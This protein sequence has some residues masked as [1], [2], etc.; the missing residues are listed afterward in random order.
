MP[1]TKAMFS[2]SRIA[3]ERIANPSFSGIICPLCLTHIQTF[4]EATREHVPPKALGGKVL[5]VLCRKCNSTA[6]HSIDAA[7]HREA[8]A[9]R[10]LG[11]DGYRTEVDLEQGSGRIRAEI[12]MVNDEINV[13]VL[14][15]RS[16]PQMENHLKELLSS[17]S[18]HGREVRVRIPFNYRPIDASVGHLK[19]AYLAAFAKFG[20]T[21]IMSRE[22]DLIRR[23]IVCPSEPIVPRFRV[24]LVRGTETSLDGF[25]RLKSPF[26]ALLVRRENVGIFLP[27]PN[28]KGPIEISDWIHAEASKTPRG[29]LSLDFLGQWPTKLELALDFSGST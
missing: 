29:S 3:L 27:I 5:C 18:A 13:E 9:A 19:V 17:D 26:P 2:K 21:V 25:Y 10:F 16:D 28:G 8:S 7:I 24:E 4:R 15:G 6:G 20:Y 12:F 11:Q 1:S 22:Y 23:Q 14:K